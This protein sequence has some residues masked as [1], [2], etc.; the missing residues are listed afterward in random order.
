MENA[1]AI[2]FAIV[3]AAVAWGSL[4]TWI[5]HSWEDE[6]AFELEFLNREY[7]ANRKK[8]RPERWLTK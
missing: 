5:K 8:R 4:K 2:C 1:I 6:D 3:I 7:L